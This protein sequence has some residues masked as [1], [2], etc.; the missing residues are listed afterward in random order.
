MQALDH[1]T[2]IAPSLAEGVEHVRAYLDL[3][4]PFG[5]RHTYMGTHNHRLRLGGRVY[6][7]IVALDPD[8][9]DPGR[10]RWFG[11]DDQEKI[12]SDWEAGRRLRGWV[13]NT[14]SI[15]A[16][17]SSYGGVFGEEVSLPPKKPEFGFT[18]PPDGSL[19]MDGAMPSFIDHRG[20]P[21]SMD[22]IP[23]LGATLGAWSLKH[24][25]PDTITA[26]YD[27]LAI[28]HAPLVANGPHLSYR[29]EINTPS[30]LRVL[31]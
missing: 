26:L 15:A 20:N 7:E 3:D 25:E 29:A 2:I 9:I 12:R 6:L 27:A 10:S 23:D 11:L 5:T 18:I 17:L 13:A 16:I 24:P 30:G 4:I 14:T 19:P 21:T 28:E 22:E 1:L 31:T 8:G